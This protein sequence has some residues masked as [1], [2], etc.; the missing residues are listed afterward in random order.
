M[1]ILSRAINSHFQ[2]LKK[3]F[4]RRQEFRPPKLA[5]SKL[6]CQAAFGFETLLLSIIRGDIDQS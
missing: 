4:H 2:T 6:C 1:N 3:V 5:M